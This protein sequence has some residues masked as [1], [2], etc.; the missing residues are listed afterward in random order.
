MCVC[1]RVYARVCVCLKRSYHVLE[2]IV[3]VRCFHRRKLPNTHVHTCRQDVAVDLP[4]A[5]YTA[6]QSPR[7]KFRQLDLELRQMPTYLDV[8]LEVSPALI[9]CVFKPG[10]GEAVALLVAGSG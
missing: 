7:V 4:A 6:E 2:V 9:T 5:L 10:E 8:F 3:F 1:V